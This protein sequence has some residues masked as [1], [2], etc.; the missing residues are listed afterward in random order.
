MC[1]KPALKKITKRSTYNK[2][3]SDPR[4]NREKK[5]EIALEMVKMWAN[6]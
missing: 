3:E 5:K 2:K 6:K 4:W 1:S